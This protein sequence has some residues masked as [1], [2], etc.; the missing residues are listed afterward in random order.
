MAA[1]RAQAQAE[2]GIVILERE[3]LVEAADLI[4]QRA[5]GGEHRARHHRPFALGE[6]PILI[7]AG[8]ARAEQPG[9]RRALAMRDHAGML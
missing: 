3:A 1:E 4:H 2:V 5:T 8:Y 7:G 9:V 6:R